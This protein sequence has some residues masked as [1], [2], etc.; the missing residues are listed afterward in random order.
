MLLGI[1][2]ETLGLAIIFPVLDIM[3]TPEKINK[4]HF[5]KDVI[6][7]DQLVSIINL[8]P[9]LIILFYV[10]KSLYLVY[11]YWKQSEFSANLGEKISINLFSTYLYRPYSFHLN[12][13]SSELHRNIKTETLQF[14]EVIK[15]LLNIVLESLVLISIFLI[16][17]YVEPVASFSMLTFGILLS[18]LYSK[19]TSKKLAKWGE[20]RQEVS[21]ETSKTIS[22]A[23]GGIKDV[24][25]LELEKYYLNKYKSFNDQDVRIQKKMSTVS[26]LPRL[27]L[28]FVAVSGLML[29]ILIVKIRGGSIQ[30]LI[31]VLGI[32]LASAFRTIPSINRIITSIQYINFSKPVIQLLKNEFISFKTHSSREIQNSTN[33]NFKE[34]VI[35]EL[36][37]SYDSMS[38]LVLKDINLT[39]NKGD[40][41]GLIGESGVGKSTFVDLILGI[42]QPN[43]GTL[44]FNGKDILLPDTNWNHQLGYIQQNVFLSD[45]TLV[46][47]I[48]LGIDAK[49]VDF[50]KLNI[51]I[52]QSQLTN[53]VKELPLG[54]Q[55]NVGERGL[56]ISGGQRQRIGIARALYRNPNFLVF[57]EATSNLDVQTEAAIMSSI[58]DLSLTKTIIII[59][60]RK[61]ALSF[62]N[63]IYKIQN[64]NLK[65]ETQ[66]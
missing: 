60:H 61:S 40:V 59:A 3:S 11:L 53:F 32:F 4:Y 39:I 35:S 23:F 10:I 25:I 27:F 52:D 13:N 66:N 46:A 58:K 12:T 49:D 45:D 44:L 57:D 62:C 9:V 26:F 47:N 1:V 48:A 42:N 20:I 7:P 54:L 16:L 30:L 65:L 17:M 43:S 8:L 24:K 37:F 29:F 64:G 15:S 41:I 14:T 55:T 5:L 31:P 38:K 56:R 50:K 6:N 33:E 63:K 36:N 19:I 34:L 51:A 28:E 2:F 22:H 21:T 18:F